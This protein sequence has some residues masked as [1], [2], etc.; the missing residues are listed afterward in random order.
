MT[1]KYR[2]LAVERYGEKGM[3]PTR[4]DVSELPQSLHEFP[5]CKVRVLACSAGKGTRSSNKSSCWCFI[6][7]LV[8]SQH[9]R[10]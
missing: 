10:K 5:I 4:R 2:Q 3:A 1:A 7:A 9:P 8:K 6:R